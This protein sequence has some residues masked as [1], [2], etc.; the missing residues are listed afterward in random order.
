[1][2]GYLEEIRVHYGT[3]IWC[4]SPSVPD[5]ARMVGLGACGMT[6]NPHIVNRMVQAASERWRPEVAACRAEGGDLTWNLTRR[7]IREALAVLEPLYRE[8]GGEKGVGCIQVN[9]NLWDDTEAMVALAKEGHA[10]AS[11]AA[12]KIPVTRAGVAAIEE[13]SAWNVS[14]NGT[15]VYTT[16]QLVAIAEAFRRGKARAAAAGRLDPKRPLHSY[17]TLMVGRL[18]DHLRDVTR[19]AGL[20]VAPEVMTWAGIA[21]AKH[22]HAIF[23]ERGY[24]SR[25]LIAAMRGHYHIAQFIGGDLIVTTPPPNEEAFGDYIGHRCPPPLMQEPVPQRMLDELIERF[26]DF[27][28]A[29]DEDGLR[30]E[31][32]ASFGAAVKTLDQFKGGWNELVR[33]VG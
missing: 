9:P 13:L 25:I 6:C 17:A 27:R 21:V 2:S 19:E 23:K 10:V 8:T 7:V 5:L 1:M 24:E 14:T 16:S 32:F 20:N 18:D 11:N 31:E 22:A 15:V 4:D 12:V 3:D 26:A 29:Y 30:P 28:R 33:W